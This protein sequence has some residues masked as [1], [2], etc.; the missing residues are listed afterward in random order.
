MSHKH[1]RKHHHENPQSNPTQP[2]L[3]A[4]KAVPSKDNHEPE[5]N[6]VNNPPCC[7]EK[8]T[9]HW[10]SPE[11]LTTIFTGLLAF[12]AMGSFLLLWL[13]LDDARKVFNTD[14]RPWMEAQSIDGGWSVSINQ[15]ITYKLKISNIGKTPAKK[16]SAIMFLEKVANGS[17]PKI[18]IPGP[19]GAA[20]EESGIMFPNG[21]M[22]VTAIRIDNINNSAVETP[23]S[24]EEMSELSQ[25]KA[26]LVVYGRIE[27]FDSSGTYHWTHFCD[28]HGFN[29]SVTYSAK[30]C[31]SYNDADGN[32]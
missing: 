17:P 13:Q 12:F 5:C 25:G 15:P 22:D 19:K 23:L 30:L 10:T 3:T 7:E 28:W 27:Y 6:T 26:Y 1:G 32:S 9:K 21:Y 20:S 29:Q 16:I 8:P 4:S 18:Y 14:Q 2:P 24:P 11:G 31:T